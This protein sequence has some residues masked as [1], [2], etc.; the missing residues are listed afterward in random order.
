MTRNTGGQPLGFQPPSELRSVHSLDRQ[1]ILFVLSSVA[2]VGIRDSATL[3]VYARKLAREVPSMSAD[4]L[5]QVIHALRLAQFSKRSLLNAVC[6]QLK[7]K[8]DNVTPAALVRAMADL[9]SLRHLDGPLQLALARGV[10][11]RLPNCGTYYL[12]LLLKCFASV[13]VRDEAR[14]G[15][16]GQEVLHRIGKLE[17][18]MATQA[19]YSLAILDFGHDGTAAGLAE[20]ALPRMLVDMGPSHL[21]AL[22]YALVVLDLPAAELLSFILT[23]IVRELHNLSIVQKYSLT[24]VRQCLQFP[25]AL[26]PAMRTALE[27]DDESILRCTN[28]LDRILPDKVNANDETTISKFQVGL[29]NFLDQ[30]KVP[31]QSEEV[32]GPYVLDYVLPKNIAVE[33]D[34]YTHFYAFSRRMTA[35]TEL[36]R[37]VLTAMGWRVVN[38]PHFEWIP[39]NSS[40][41]LAF[42]A[43]RI[44]TVAAA[45]LKTLRGL[46]R[47]MPAKLRNPQTALKPSPPVRGNRNYRR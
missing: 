5:C 33:V 29:E 37:R 22:A 11:E 25:A 6:R 43:E 32:V 4:E 19:F 17:A 38:V 45:P 40:D 35:K 34:G 13:S 21:I 23:R 7:N 42:L 20:Q 44:E 10:L 2:K 14:I 12:P 15:Q 26:K 3:D 9:K 31:H 41:R 30:L 36:K 1:Q 46:Q 18:S 47:K 24:I 28:A 16:I 39:R 8:V 27:R